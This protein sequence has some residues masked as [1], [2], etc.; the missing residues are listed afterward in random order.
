MANLTES[1]VYDSG[2][3]QIEVSDI[4]EGGASGIVNMGAKNLANRTAYLKTHVDALES[5]TAVFAPIASPTFTGTVGGITKAMVGLGS[6][7]NTPD[8]DKPVSTPAQTALNLK[9]NANNSALTG[10]PTA[11]TAANG[12][13]TTQLAS[14]AFVVLE[15]PAYARETVSP[16]D[17]GAVLDGTT[18]DTTAWRNTIAT[19]KRI[20]F[21]V[22]VSKIT[23]KLTFQNGQIIQGS[24]RTKS[25]FK[26]DSAS[27]NMS[28]T[29]V[30]QLGT[31]E[32]G[33]Q[34]FDVGIQFVQV[35]QAVRASI[36]AYPPAIDGS[37]IPRFVLDRIRIEQAYDGIK[38]T[39][40]C[41]GAYIGFIEVGALRKGLEFNGALDFVH[42][43]AW[44]FWPF[45][46]PSTLLN[47]VY[48]DGVT[49]AFTCGQCDGLEVSSISSFSASIVFTSAVSTPIP[50]LIGKLQLDNDGATLSV[51]GGRISIGQCYTTK[52]GAPVVPAIAVT[53]GFLSINQLFTS[54]VQSA[55]IASITSTGTL[56][57]NGGQFTHT[58]T[59][60]SWFT[61]SAGQLN[62]R[63]CNFAASAS[64]F[65]A[66]HI[67]Q[68]S[69]GGLTLK[70]NTWAGMGAGSGTAVSVTT[71]LS[72]NDISDN[73]FKEWTYTVPVPMSAG[74]YGV[75]KTA[76][77][78]WTPTVIFGTLGDF[79][80]SYTTREGFLQYEKNGIWFSCRLVF[81]TNAFTTASGGFKVTGL[82]ITASAS[83]SQS[84]F[85]VDR[86]SNIDLTTNYSFIDASITASSSDLVLNQSGDNVA[87]AGLGITNIKPSITGI[88]FS[89]CGFVRS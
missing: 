65:S 23:D 87:L 22:G 49:N 15:I 12:T 58:A 77:K 32:P 72:T 78:A 1:S 9:A 79:S 81:T 13:S 8:T 6:A 18:D 63:N 73:D 26:V 25:Y 38:A 64:A 17:L 71:D 54:H 50:L 21:P 45:G 53:N 10:V 61:V 43:C 29:S 83:L 11:P 37:S 2:V 39:G 89:I 85:S 31:A 44:H 7:N 55:P 47:G 24:G 82:P 20:N 76:I 69:T 68:S 80:P 75:N 52:S 67:A 74:N 16:T 36:T 19:G 4:A 59:N 5:S 57:I 51:A 27:F 66:P 60:I 28:A 56:N 88:E 86:C 35:N 84:S 70:S 41:G 34:L 33:A 62:I 40:N 48:L 42:G 46:M 3:Y 30:L 14:T